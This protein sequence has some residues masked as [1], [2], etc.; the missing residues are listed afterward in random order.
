VKIGPVGESFN[1]VVLGVREGWPNSPNQGVVGD[2]VRPDGPVRSAVDTL[3]S[4]I[5]RPPSGQLT[6]D[7]IVLLLQDDNTT[8]NVDSFHSVS[9]L[10]NINENYST[11][12]IYFQ[13]EQK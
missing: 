11:F 7:P 2:L 8:S 9:P 12:P 3:T 4:I 10:K 13:G 1:S 6:E 5:V